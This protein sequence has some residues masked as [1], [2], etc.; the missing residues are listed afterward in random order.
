M[1][2]LA[3]AFI[4]LLPLLVTISYPDGLPVIEA[5]ELRITTVEVVTEEANAA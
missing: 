3:V 2:L 4:G 5:G 1:K